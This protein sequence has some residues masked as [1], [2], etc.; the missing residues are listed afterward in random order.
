MEFR[1]HWLSL[2]IWG[3]LHKALALWDVWFSPFLGEMQ[4]SGHGGR[5]FQ[6][7]YRSLA[8]ARLSGLPAGIEERDLERQYFH[9][10]L[11]GQAC[12]AIPDQVFRE[13]LIDLSRNEK[14]NVTRVDLAWDGV[15]FTPEQVKQ[16]V[17]D[18]NIRS[19]VKRKSMKYVTSPYAERDNGELGTS[20][21]SL[22]SR[23]STRMIRVYDKRGPVRIE[24]QVREDR[25][26]L[27]TKEVLTQPVEMWPELCV[28][29]LRDYIDFLD[30]EE[31]KL[32]DW[33]EQFVNEKGRANK[34]VTDARKKE[35]DRIL[36][37][38][39]TQVST[40]LSVVADVIGEQA[41]QAFIIDGRRKRGKRFDAVLG[42]KLEKE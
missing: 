32:L 10:E 28:S 30:Q 2:T 23:Q 6:K 26:L 5:G 15:D 25:A 17:D 1:I 13:F 37:W 3:T 41:I 35:L 27:I 12:D 24:F 7:L 4:S 8:Q 34:T 11:P 31:Q 20:T 40:S 36:A 42:V 21:L 38:I 19:S 22:G 18:E 14:F 33:W 39:D 9:I 29:H 16:A